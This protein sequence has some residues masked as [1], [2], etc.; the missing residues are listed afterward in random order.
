[1][2]KPREGA[3]QRDQNS[4]GG[5]QPIRRVRHQ[6]KVNIDMAAPS[7]AWSRDA[8][9]VARAQRGDLAAFEDLIR[10]RLDRLFRTACGILGDPSEAEDAAQETAIAAWQ[11]LP[12]LKDVERLD[13]WLGRILLNTCRMRLRSRR[14]VREIPMDDSRTTGDMQDNSRMTEHAEDMDRVARALDS[15]SA[16]DRALLILHHV[17]QERVDSIAATLGIPTGTVK[18]RLSRAR[19]AVQRAMESDQRALETLR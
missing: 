14:R 17:H 13:A 19:Q 3:S 7:G 1:L 11:K 18:W 10:T 2:A 8:D 5:C 12:S 16:D 6:L 4:D 15:V 9:L